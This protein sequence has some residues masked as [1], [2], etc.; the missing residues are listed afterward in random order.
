M[1]AVNFPTKEIFEEF[2]SLHEAS[3]AFMAMLEGQQI[4]DIVPF[5]VEIVK[6]EDRVRI[7]MGGSVDYGPFESDSSEDPSPESLF[8]IA[9]AGPSIAKAGILQSYEEKAYDNDYKHV[10]EAL[11]TIALKKL[12]KQL[13]DRQIAKITKN[14]HQRMY[15]ILSEERFRLGIS[16]IKEFMTSDSLVERNADNIHYLIEG[17][18]SNYGIDEG[19]LQVMRETIREK[20]DPCIFLRR[21]FI[22]RL[23]MLLRKK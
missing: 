16:L 2:I 17:H 21:G 12:G 9:L 8:R 6:Y 5:E 14:A 3:H 15:E 11:Q 23:K 7:E 1:D 13:S 22:D 20:I 10:A 18:L 19:Q 4:Y